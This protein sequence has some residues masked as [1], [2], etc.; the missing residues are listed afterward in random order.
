MEGSVQATLNF[1]QRTGRDG[2]VPPRV[3]KTGTDD[4]SIETMVSEPLPTT[5]LDARAL[6][7]P[8]SLDEHGFALLQHA[9]QVDFENVDEIRAVYYPEMEA[10]V[11]RATGAERVV[12][13]DH[14]LRR[15]TAESAQASAGGRGIGVAAIGGWAT[16]GVNRVH[17][18]YT[19]A[20]APRRVTQ[21][22]I[23][24]DSGSFG[25]EPP[26]TVAE[27][28][29]IVSGRRR[30]AVVNVWRSTASGDTPVETQPLAV[31][32]CSSVDEEDDLFTVELVF[33]DRVGENLGVDH[34]PQR[35]R[36]F[37][38]SSM[39]PDECLLFKAFDSSR[40]GG[41]RGKFALHTAFDHQAT[42]EHS[43]PRESCEC[44]LLVIYPPDSSV[45]QGQEQGQ[46]QRKGSGPKL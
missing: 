16:A 5:I 25:A 46:G 27:A 11:Q 38:Y 35:H 17:G 7:A 30:F 42:T 43:A 33:T 24:S 13:F 28:E 37:H 14:T 21:L 20:G 44:R 1:V 18:D 9:T 15:I 6:T 29:E 31:L 39:M 10:L 34:K 8:A 41:I 4:A 36:W 19:L 23:P 40:D 22:S 26:L 2:S 3:N 12:L 45:E 32:D